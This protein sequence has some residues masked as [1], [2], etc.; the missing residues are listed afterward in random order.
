MASRKS[1]SED[2]DDDDEDDEAATSNAADASNK[3]LKVVI[4]L[5]FLRQET[6]RHRDSK[7]K[8]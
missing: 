1:F 7:R 6:A 8:N 5:L 3:A 2:D 4:S